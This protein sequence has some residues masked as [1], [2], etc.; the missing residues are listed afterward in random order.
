MKKPKKKKKKKNW[1]AKTFY[2]TTSSLQT[3]DNYYH[4]YICLY[5]NSPT[6]SKV[7]LQETSKKLDTF[8][9][10]NAIRETSQFV[11]RQDIRLEYR[12][13]FCIH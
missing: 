10:I 8:L 4:M 6:N 3:E 5:E 9:C 2:G 13:C 7:T 12:Q 1:K 11:L